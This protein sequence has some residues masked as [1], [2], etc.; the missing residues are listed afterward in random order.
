MN[1][2]Q[3][4]TKIRRIFILK[5]NIKPNLGFA[6]EINIYIYVLKVRKAKYLVIHNKV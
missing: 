4:F 5:S 3:P 2:S 1:A 6:I